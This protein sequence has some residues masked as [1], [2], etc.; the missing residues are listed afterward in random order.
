[1]RVFFSVGEPSG[2]LH[3]ANLIA[4]LRCFMDR[5]SPL[6][7]VGFGGPRMAAAGCELLADMTELAVM[8]LFPVLAKLPRFFEL[9]DRAVAYFR[10]QRPDAV[11][12]IDYPGFNWHIA[13]AAKDAGIPVFY[14]GLPQLWAWAPWRVRKV[15]ELVDHALVKLPFEERWFRDRDCN[16]TYVGHPYFDELRS[17]RLD[18]P[19]LDR[20]AMQRGRLVTILPGSRTVEVTSNLPQLLR[21]ARYVQREVPGVR[22]AVASYNERQAQRAR[23]IV[24]RSGTTADVYVG[25]T[26]ELILSAQACLACSGS[27]SL[28]LLFHA[29][30]S[31]VLYSVPW[32]TYAVVR[33]L[34]KV[35]YITLV[36][37]LATDQIYADAEHPAPYDR[38][39]PGHEDVLL[40]EYPTWRDRSADLASH[41]IEWLTDEPARQRAIA[42]LTELRDRV[43]QG[44]A[45]ARAAEYILE[46]MS[47]HETQTLPIGIASE[48]AVYRKAS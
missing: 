48:R 26:P 28:E 34:V 12:L 39:K 15:R 8:G 17:Q 24:E 40:P 13:R 45:S 31:V 9:R 35:R 46:H 4:E 7:A 18:H 32:W 43:A 42:R 41:V 38:H 1:M 47:P 33:R 20:L 21:A 16:A 36:N 10:D 29:K 14:Y 27:V 19:F 23:R 5:G 3:G 6:E 25:R 22:L 37:L 2:D 30:P 11:V 44:G